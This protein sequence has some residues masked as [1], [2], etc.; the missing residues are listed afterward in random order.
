VPDEKIPLRKAVDGPTD[1]PA[2]DDLIETM[3]D[4]A[5]KSTD[6]R[7]WLLRITQAATIVLTE[8]HTNTSHPKGTGEPPK[9]DFPSVIHDGS[10]IQVTAH[11][12]ELL[13]GGAQCIFVPGKF[14]PGHLNKYELYRGDKKL[15][16]R[17]VS[18]HSDRLCNIIQGGGTQDEVS[19]RLGVSGR[20]AEI[21]Q[22]WV[23]KPQQH[24]AGQ[25]HT[26]NT[27]A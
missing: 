2:L 5:G 3:R 13:E 6:G 21:T 8:L 14:N 10:R 17:V 1:P 15:G 7:L 26:R 9:R 11:E 22:L 16:Y 27:P 4:H 18:T 23:R 12:V 19:S 20:I 25:D 24:P